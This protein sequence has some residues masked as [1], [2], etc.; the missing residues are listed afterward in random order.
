MLKYYCFAVTFWN[1]L[2]EIYL[3]FRCRNQAACPP[4]PFHTQGRKKPYALPGT[5]LTVSSPRS[6]VQ[7]QTGQQEC[8]WYAYW[9]LSHPVSFGHS[10]CL[11]SGTHSLQQPSAVSLCLSAPQFGVGHCIR[12][13]VKT[14]CFA[15][16]HS[17][18]GSFGCVNTSPVIIYIRKCICIL[19]KSH[20]LLLVNSEI[21]TLLTK[22]FF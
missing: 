3:S 18:H 8:L 22:M 4:P 20:L 21:W 1:S 16:R 5:T 9:S 7:P 19:M 2:K 6:K 10:F 11:H 12:L 14:P 13:H 17:A 15:Q